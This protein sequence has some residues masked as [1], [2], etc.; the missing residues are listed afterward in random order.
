VGRRLRLADTEE[1]MTVVGVVADFR[2]SGLAGAPEPGI[3]G[4]IG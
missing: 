1:W 2:G 4:V 3:Y